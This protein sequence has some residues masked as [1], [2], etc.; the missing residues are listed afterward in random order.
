MNEELKVRKAL[1]KDAEKIINYLKKTVTQTDFLSY[2]LDEF[3]VTISQEVKYI[4]NLSK[5]NS[6]FFIAEIGEEVV[7]KVTM[8][9]GKTSRTEH[10]AELSMSVDKDYWGRKIGSKLLQQALDWAF[11]SGI[12]TKVVLKVN[13]NN[14]VAISLY[15]RFGFQKEGKLKN[16]L[17]VNGEYVDSIL[18]AKILR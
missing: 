15:Q 7:G 16:D 13:H 8:I 9:G 6:V 2:T 12:I 18:M 17:K 3:K 11:Q 4:Q 14:P 1:A 10:V 5:P